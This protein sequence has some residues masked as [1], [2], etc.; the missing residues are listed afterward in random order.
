MMMCSG[1]HIY[2]CWNSVLINGDMVARK[3]TEAILEEARKL[4]DF[5]QSFQDEIRRLLER[6][7]EVEQQHEG[8]LQQKL[9]QIIQQI[10]HLTTAVA[11]GIGSRS[12]LEKLQEREAEQEQI[13]DELSQIKQSSKEEFRLPTAEQIRQCAEE[14]LTSFIPDTEEVGRLMQRLIPELAVYPYRL[15]DG[16]AIV[17]RAKFKLYLPAFLNGKQPNHPHVEEILERSLIVDLF[18]LPQRVKYREAVIQM[19]VAGMTERQ[20]AAALG[21]THTAAQRAASLDR[22][23]KRENLED[24]Y[25]ELTSPPED[26]GK[27]RR[28]KHPRYRF[29]PLDE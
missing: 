13:Q 17:L 22:L 1:A 21:I 3:L 7:S 9:R 10:T 15:C 4:P 28:H 23:M 19:R 18:D 16:G 5:S 6:K 24:P 26:S 11:E 20:V 2:R 29:E 25:L 12:L 8:E 14:A 27:L